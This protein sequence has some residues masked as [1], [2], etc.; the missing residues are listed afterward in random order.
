MGR[1]MMPVLC[2]CVVSGAA[3]AAEDAPAVIRRALDALG[4]EEQLRQVKGLYLKANGDLVEEKLR[5]SMEVFD[6]LPDRVKQVFD[7]DVQGEQHTQIHVFRRPKAW[8]HTDGVDDGVD[9]ATLADIQV[10]NHIN[11]ISR[12]VPLLQDPSY[13]IEVLRES[14]VGDRPAAVL[15][16]LAKGLPDVRLYFEKASGQLIKAEH[17]RPDPKSKKLVLHETYLSDYREVNLAT[18]DEQA[19]NAARVGTDGAALLAFLRA[20]AL[21]DRDRERIENIIQKL[22]DA[23][24]EVRESAAK[25]L[26]SAGPAAIP[27]VSRAVTNPDPEIAGRAKQCLERLGPAENPEVPASV[28]RLIAQRQP[29]GAV[30]ALLDY[31]PSVP[32]DAVG[33]EVES[34]L[35][36][37][38]YRD[39]KPDPALVKARGGNDAKRRTAA[40]KALVRGGE[41]QSVG[42]RLF[43]KGVKHPMTET[44]FK[45]GKKSVEW[46][47]TDVQFFTQFDDSVFAPP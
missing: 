6:Q 41:A 5:G 22:G 29:P 31:L 9:P 4:G 43:L 23:G 20:R 8:I 44:E 14:K 28:V 11:Y 18:K 35:A 16:V 13:R 36:A 37:L 15:Q 45:D 34:A 2:A 27:L 17:Q 1:F 26:A 21:T 24:F 38:A 47:L 10:D 12:L 3:H 46:K 40:E 39:G 30:E 7:F 33:R 32:A 42:R 25:E 19:L